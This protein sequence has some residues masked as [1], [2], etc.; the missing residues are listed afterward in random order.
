MYFIFAKEDSPTNDAVSSDSEVIIMCE[1]KWAVFDAGECFTATMIDIK[2]G[3]EE[4]V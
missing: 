3:R 4:K 2:R 1:E